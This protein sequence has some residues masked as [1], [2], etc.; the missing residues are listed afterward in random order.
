MLF[1]LS[2]SQNIEL[3]GSV[4]LPTGANDIFLSG[5]YAFIANGFSG[6]QVVDI[7]D[8]EN[9][10]L[11]GSLYEPANFKNIHIQGN[12]AYL[13]GDSSID[14]AHMQM[15]IVNI[16]NPANPQLISSYRSFG[17]HLYD[18]FVHGDYVYLARGIW[19]LDIVN[20]SNP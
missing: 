9:P 10:I 19:D 11:I 17:P 15:I 12:Y 8:P 6:L 1:P 20:V 13:A 18:L 4:N 2:F 14:H 3:V 7:S 5:D 16:N